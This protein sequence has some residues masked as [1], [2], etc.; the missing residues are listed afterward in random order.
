VAVLG[1]PATDEELAT[2]WGMVNDL[3]DQSD[4]LRRYLDARRGPN[5]LTG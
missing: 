3:L 5:P 4:G 1:L 2:L